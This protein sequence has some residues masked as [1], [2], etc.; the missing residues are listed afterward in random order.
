MKLFFDARFTRTDRHDGISRY[1]SCLL[2]ALLEVTCG[3]EVEVIAIIHDEAQLALLPDTPYVVLNHPTSPAELTIAKRLDALGADVVFSTMQVMGSWGRDHALVL[4]LHDLIYYAH[5]QPPADLPAVVRGAWRLYHRAYWPQRLML[6]RADAVAVV[7]RTTARLVAEHALTSRPVHVVP[8][9]VAPPPELPARAPGHDARS[10]VYM[11]AFLPYKNVEALIRALAH[12]PGWTLHLP[13]RITPAR[14]RELR[15]LVPDRA[16]VVFHRGASD[17]EYAALLDSATA[18]VTASL[19]EGFGL[20]V[21]EAMARGVPVAVSE[22]PIFRELADGVAEF[23]DPHDPADIAHAVSAL[24]V[25]E[26][27]AAR[28]QAAQVRAAE[29]SWE[30]SAE[31]LLDLARSL[32]A[33]RTRR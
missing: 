5:P 13:S 11:G 31:V 3:T 24:S 22:L 1:G 12:L 19:D 33:E 20:P 23:F 9:A 8:N 32:H 2:A 21:V 27:W 26:V 28:A 15:A 17:E 25:P 30:S 10:L 4:T 16:R 6:D 29:F 14:E 7:S 18:L